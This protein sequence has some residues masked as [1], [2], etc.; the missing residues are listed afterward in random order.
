M[1]IITNSLITELPFDLQHHVAE[2]LTMPD[3]N[4]CMQV[5]QA[6]KNLFSSDVM[7][8]PIAKEFKVEK[9]ELNSIHQFINSAIIKYL[10]DFFRSKLNDYKSLTYQK[11]VLEK[12]YFQKKYPEFME[13]FDG[14]TAILHLPTIEMTSDEMI[15]ERGLSGLL[16]SY[17]F[18][19]K[20]FTSPIV[21]VIF[22]ENDV[23]VIFKE[24]DDS[25][26]DFILLRIRNNATGKIYL[27]AISFFPLGGMRCF[28]ML[29][30]RP[31]QGVI[32]SLYLDVTKERLN[33]LQR[34]IQGK[35]VGVILGETR[36]SIN[37]GP[38]TIENKKSTLELF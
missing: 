27:D 17:Y 9:I 38:K 1:N 28:S 3:L 19:D 5:S 14:I 20:Y 16:E 11:I 7:W 12:E 37:E 24:S 31:G 18:R 29:N 32:C 13:V 10:P 26:R 36:Y 21:R 34:L 2:Y 4:K 33:R 15:V 22:K 6:W 35:P 8:R 25:Q 30:I 23:R